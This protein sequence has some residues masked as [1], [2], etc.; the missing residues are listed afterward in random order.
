LFNYLTVP[1][2]GHFVPNPQLNYYKAAYAFFTDYLANK[3][4]TC[5]ST[6]GNGCSVTSSMCTYMGNCFGLGDCGTNGQCT[7]NNPGNG[8]KWKGAD[9]SMQSNRLKNELNIYQFSKGPKWWSFYYDGSAAAKKIMAVTTTNT[10]PMDV[11][12][13]IGSDSTPTEFEFDF[14]MK[15]MTG[16]FTL[17]SD[18]L[19]QYLNDTTGFTVAM[20]VDGIVQQTNTLLEQ[21]VNVQFSE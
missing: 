14:E 4:L 20:Y 1:K 9:C 3:K 17:H 12:V 5:Q 13:S 19:P 11:Y 18:D 15:A 7:C 2:A 16:N 10:V 8:M 21:T 6:K